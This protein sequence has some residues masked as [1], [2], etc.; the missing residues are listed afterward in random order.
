LHEGRHIWQ[1]T[2]NPLSEVEA[3][4]DAEDYMWQPLLHIGFERE[5]VVGAMEECGYV[6]AADGPGVR[7]QDAH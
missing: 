5:D 1:V 3:E 4:R 2:T 6:E 7:R